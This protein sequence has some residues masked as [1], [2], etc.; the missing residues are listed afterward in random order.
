MPEPISMDLRRRI[1]RAVERGNSIHAAARGFAFSPSTAIK[2]MQ[3]MRATGSAAPAC[4]RGH[5]RPL[6]APYEADLRRLVEASP[7]LTLA[8]LQHESSAASASFPLGE[9]L[10]AAVPHGHW[11]H[12]D[13]RDWPPADR[14]RR[15]A[16]ARRPDDR[17][18]VPRLRRLRHPPRPPMRSCRRGSATYSLALSD[19]HRRSRK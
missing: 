19:D 14:D 18:R 10:R 13:V 15:G 5:L 11:T 12:D 16:G 7:G 4:Y 2:L 8:E 3:R 1:V 9:R 6:L 17:R